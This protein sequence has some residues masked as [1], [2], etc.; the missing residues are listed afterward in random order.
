MSAAEILS[1]PFHSAT[2]K[3][4]IAFI[5]PKQISRDTLRMVRSKL[6]KLARVEFQVVEFTR[7]KLTW[8]VSPYQFKAPYIQVFDTS[9][10]RLPKSIKIKLEAELIE[11]YEV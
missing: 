2:P 9:E 1:L 5:Q 10:R 4:A 7:D 6:E 11:N 8:S 3:Q